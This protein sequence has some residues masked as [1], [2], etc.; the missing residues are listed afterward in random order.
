MIGL[1]ASVSLACNAAALFAQV[2]A[3]TG[4][5][6]WSRVGEISA[7]GALTSSGL[8]GVAELRDDVRDGRY[9]RWSSLA[10]KGTEAEVYDGQTVWARDISGGVHPYDSWYPRSRAVTQAFLARRGYLDSHSGAVL[11]CAGIAGSGAAHDELVRATP[12]GGIPADVAVNTRS[13]LI[14]SIAIRTPISTDVTT[15]ADYRQVGALVLPFSISTA[16]LFEPQN[17]D[18]VEVT[19]YAVADRVKAADF[20]KPPAVDNAKMLGGSASTTVPI[21][22]EGH[23]LFVWASIDG[24]APMPFILDSGGHAILD[25]VAAKALGLRGT[26]GGVSGGAGAG[27]IALQYTRVASVRI[28][29][30][31]LLDQPFLIIPYPYAFYERGRKVPLAGILGLEWFERYAT[32]ID[33]I[34]Q[35]LTLTPL[36]SFTYRGRGTAVP[37]RF[38][39]DMPLADATADG[40]AGDFGVDTGNAGILILYGDFLRRAGLFAKYGQGA[41]VHGAGTGGSNSGEL[42]TLARFEIGSHEI[43]KL[44]ADFTQMTTGAFSS[45]T[46][47]GDLGLSVL[48]RFTATF[49]YANQTLY[50]EPL[51]HPLVIARNRSGIGFAKNGPDAI[52][53][54]AVRPNSAASAVSIAAG[55]QILAVNGTS[56]RDLSAAD[57]VAIVTGRPGTMLELTVRHG[58][59]TRDVKLVLPK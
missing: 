21:E 40:T 35:R 18:R 37:I 58:A 1:I 44:L 4:G 45:W 19:R 10:V 39:E 29:D 56:A 30:A 34:G 42:Q 57:F 6:A 48:S 25:G 13:H 55:D 9:A 31:E 11:T 7:S 47:A 5:A 8:H 24:H 33:Y 36:A 15:F 12:R 27:T 14:D 17:G 41:I 32:R 46:E 59:A 23:Q 22:L 2:A 43:P 50:L 16:S 38:Q 51:A 3:A 28:G 49:D 52:D 26:G 20:Q 54:V 53:V